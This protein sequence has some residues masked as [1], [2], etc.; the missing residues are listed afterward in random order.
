MGKTYGIDL[1]FCIRSISFGFSLWNSTMKH[2]SL[3]IKIPLFKV[4]FEFVGLYGCLSDET[5][6]M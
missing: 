1:T 3:S 2:S 5:E 6:R 4:A